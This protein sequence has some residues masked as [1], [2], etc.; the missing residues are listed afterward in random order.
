MSKFKINTLELAWLAGLLEGEGCFGMATKK[1]KYKYPFIQIK[2]TDYDV[3][4]RVAQLFNKDKVTSA[5]T[6]PSGKIAYNTYVQGNDAI[7]VMK[8]LLPHM[9]GR[10]ANKIQEIFDLLDEKVLARG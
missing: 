6:L 4:I 2:M 5:R 7:E 3:I 9:F 8:M 1:D 10:R